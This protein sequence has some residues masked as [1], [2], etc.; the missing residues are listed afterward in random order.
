MVRAWLVFFGEGARVSWWDVFT[1]PGF[2]H[3]SAAGYDVEASVWVFV[4]PARSRM[5]VDV[6]ADEAEADRRL[7]AIALA[8]RHCLRMAPREERRLSPAMFGC[9]GA[10]KALLGVRCR[11]LS[12]RGLYRHLADIGAEPVEVP[13]V[14]VQSAEGAA[15]PAGRSIDRGDEAAAAGAG[16]G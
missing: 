10:M 7:G 3:V 13:R 9:V 8:A 16:R 12:P 1:A 15:P 6:V 2:R 5:A 4:D 14:D 11:A